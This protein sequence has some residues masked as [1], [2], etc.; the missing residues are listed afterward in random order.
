M[1]LRRII[2]GNT[3]VLHVCHVKKLFL[4]HK[5]IHCIEKNCGK[6]NENITFIPDYKELYSGDLK[7]QFCVSRLLKDNFKRRVPDK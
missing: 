1:K 5:H 6:Q 2:G 7:Y 4:K 3:L